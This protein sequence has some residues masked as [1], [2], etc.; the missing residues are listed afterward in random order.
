M[1][2][3]TSPEDYASQR[4]RYT[5]ITIAR[6]VRILQIAT[7]VPIVGV[8]LNVSL[9]LQARLDLGHWPEFT[10]SRMAPNGS[11]RFAEDP[12]PSAYQALNTLRECFAAVCLVI[13]PLSGLAWCAA[14][15]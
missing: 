9:V 14:L 7:A 12:P 8:L 1:D 2:K 13:V 3:P 10:S 6:L 11:G 15:V 4:S 5:S